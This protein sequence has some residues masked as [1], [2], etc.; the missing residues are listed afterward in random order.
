MLCTHHWTVL[1]HVVLFWAVSDL[2]CSASNNSMHQIV[3]FN[4]HK[5]LF[6]SIFLLT[7]FIKT[8][9][10]LLYNYPSES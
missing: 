10:H 3:I 2:F 9:L 7:A 4:H 1:Y 6:F 5:I 8:L